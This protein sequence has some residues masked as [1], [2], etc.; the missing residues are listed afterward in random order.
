MNNKEYIICAAIWYQDGIVRFNQPRNVESG[1]VVGGW[2][3]GN[4]ISTLK[5]MFYDDFQNCEVCNK[6]RI[7][8]L[9]N[10][11][12]GFL[13]NKGNFVDREVGLKIAKENNQLINKASDTKTQLFSEDIY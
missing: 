1:I 5:T 4:C 9:N 8:V 3:H 12:Q 11:I 7:E 2:R 10:D 6:K 13:T